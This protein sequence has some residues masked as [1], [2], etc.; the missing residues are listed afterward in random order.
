MLVGIGVIGVAIAVEVGEKPNTP[1]LPD[2][3]YVVH[4]GTRPQPRKVGSGGAI[5]VKAPSDA[6]VLFD[7]SNTDAWKGNWQVKDGVLVASPGGL[8]T[9]ESFGSCQ[10]HL[11]FRVPA[12]REVKGQKGGNSGVFLM[13]RYEIQVG[14]SFANQ[15]YPDG[16]TGAIYG[17]TPP[18]VNSSTP[19]GEW[20]SFDIIFDAP[21]Y[22]DGKVVKSGEVTVLHNG[23]L[24][25]HGRQI[26]GPTSHKKLAKYPDN[27]PEAAPLNLQ[28]H[29]DPIEYRNIWIRSQGSYDDAGE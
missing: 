2:V 5:E 21:V 20:Q 22:E 6:T 10:L 9:K 15:T 29:G 26:L 17:Q 28:W 14:E 18:L 13:G 11:E 19:Q 23:V 1:K 8:S 27:H 3:P 4:D 16:Q 25:H 12:D 7:G 24:L